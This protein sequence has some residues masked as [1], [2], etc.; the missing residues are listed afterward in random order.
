MK[1]YKNIYQ[2]VC[3]MG[4][5]TFSASSCT[6][7]LTIYPQD[8]VVEENFWED[9]NDLDG[10]R[11]GAY[12]QMAQTVAKLA[13]WGDLR[14]DTYSLNTVEH[15]DQGDSDTYNQIIQGMPDSSMEVFDWGG[16]YTTINY[17]NKVLQHG[18]EV[19]AKDKQ[20]TTGEWIQMHA[21]MVALRA[22]NY[23]YLI[24]AF[25]DVPYTTK[26]VNKDS[27]VESFPLTSQLEVLDSII[28]DCERVKGKARNRFTNK[29]DSKG[30][31]TNCAIYAMLAD[32]YLWRGSLN[33][34]RHGKSGVDLV[35]GEA[36]SHNV[37]DD[38]IR[39]VECADSSLIYLAQQNKEEKSGSGL[40]VNEEETFSYG[41]NN[42]DMIKND[43]ENAGSIAPSLEAQTSI[44]KTG[45][46]R[47]SILELQYRSTDNLKNTIVNKLFG[48]D[49]GTHLMVNKS[50]FDAMYK[51]GSESGAD[52]W[53]S[54]LWVC[55]QNKLVPEEERNPSVQPLSGSYCMKY[56]LP[57]S[58]MLSMEGATTSR[59][60]K[61]VRYTST[62]YNNWII[63]RMTDV[64]LIKAEAL[65][66]QGG[67]ANTKE[68][69]SICNAIHRRSYCNYQTAGSIPDEDATKAGKY[70]NTPIPSS[71]KSAKK[72]GSVTISFNKTIVGVMYER[73]LEFIG[74]GKRWFDLVRL[75]ERSSYDKSNPDNPDERDCPIDEEA[76]KNDPNNEVMLNNM[77]TW[78]ADLSTNSEVLIEAANQT[79]NDLEDVILTYPI[80]I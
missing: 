9:K 39:A 42:C 32:M 15:S 37:N 7:W 30:M 20:F 71:N 1:S 22:L 41:L 10:V 48:Y 76:T 63:Y 28:L 14:S 66:C 75:A 27:E 61:Y 50:A 5:L 45:N 36:V 77:Q 78:Y 73:Q 40:S 35:K 24:R 62:E 58:G 8:R 31:I 25:K 17:C 52:Q 74:E 6:D 12:R 18:E 59:E 19:L 65:A 26:V 57:S 53:D 80:H 51:D 54:R 60:I 56:H 47:E 68:A 21:E 3:L 4:L 16:V 79:L 70:G 72:I 23:F 13:V 11:Y 49:N 44:F 69:E 29:R 64:M 38:Y 46:S 43:F 2:A 34:G 55:C 67:S 33:E